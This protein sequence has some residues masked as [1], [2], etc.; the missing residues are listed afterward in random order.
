[1]TE[2]TMHC[3]KVK[4]PDGRSVHGVTASG[5]PV[6]VYPGE[7]LVHCLA[8]KLGREAPPIL[9][10]VGADALGR[11]VHVP[12]AAG[13]ELQDLV[14]PA[15]STLPRT[16]AAAGDSRDPSHGGAI[17]RTLVTQDWRAKVAPEPSVNASN[18]RRVPDART[19]EHRA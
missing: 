8:P 19:V 11:D 18:R 10:F 15:V 12:L 16:S 4:V 2:R 1:M 3:F 5:Q 9:R 13:A 7:Y 14:A 6:P 17:A